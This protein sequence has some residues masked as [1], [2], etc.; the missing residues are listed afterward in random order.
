MLS[1]EEIQSLLETH[2]G[3]TLLY[4]MHDNCAPCKVFKPIVNKVIDSYNGRITLAVVDVTQSVIA[5]NYSVRSVPT[6]MLFKDGVL[7]ETHSGTMSEVEFST[8]LKVNL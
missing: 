7:V 1:D 4:F 3:L 8:M 6:V 5:R 2:S